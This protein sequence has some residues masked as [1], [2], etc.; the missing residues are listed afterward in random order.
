MT[1]DNA[2][3]A[4][5]NYGTTASAET[6]PFSSERPIDFSKTT[7]IDRQH[8]IERAKLI[9][10]QPV[11][12]WNTVLPESDTTAG[13]FRRYIAPLAAIPSICHYVGMVVFGMSLPFIGTYRWPIIGGLVYSIVMFCMTLGMMFVGAKI[14]EFLAPK[15]EGSVT[16]VNALKI[17][18][19]SATPGFL[20]GVLDIIPALSSIAALG[21]LYGLFILYQGLKAG[22]NVPSGKFIMFL[23]SAFGLNIVAGIV[24][25]AVVSAFTP[26]APMPQIDLN[27]I[28]NSME[29]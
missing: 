1:D 27:G 7:G 29:R 5:N 10:T 22:T 9:V 23:L 28:T 20:L 4:V 17:I 18:G 14:L 8:L 21:G 19:Y 12:C 26:A 15:F 25:V 3:K 11:Q 2:Q 13:L 16:E 6:S 24:M